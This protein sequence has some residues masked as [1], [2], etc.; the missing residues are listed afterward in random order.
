MLMLPLVARDEV[1]GLIELYSD[2]PGYKFTSADIR[3]AQT[4]ANQAGMAISNAQLFEEI[5]GFTQELEQRV[6]ERTEDLRRRS[7]N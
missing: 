6:Q 1:F 2:V 5:R 4:L 7:I 3:L